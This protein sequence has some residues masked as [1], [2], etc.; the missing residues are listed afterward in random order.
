MWLHSNHN[1]IHQQEPIKSS[2]TEGTTPEVNFNNQNQA[3]DPT[4]PE[5]VNSAFTAK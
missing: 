5:M 4:H 3:K 1:K 2:T